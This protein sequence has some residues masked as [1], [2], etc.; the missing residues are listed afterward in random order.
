[1][2]AY[3]VYICQSVSDRKEL[4]TYWKD[5][6]R[7]L[8]GFDIKLHTAYRPFQLLEGE[9]PGE[10]VVV[11]EF[12]SLEEAKRWYDSPGYVAVRQHRMR[13]AK[14]LG[15]LVDGGV[16]ESIDERMPSNKA[17][18]LRPRDIRQDQSGSAFA[19]SSDLTGLW[20]C[21]RFLRRPHLAR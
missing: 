16:T 13:G 3:L 9:G 21:W 11:A 19:S 15:L 14:Y 5:M 8:M 20:F 1:M 2:P 10:G 17:E 12:P 4:E 6:P 18:V 7:T